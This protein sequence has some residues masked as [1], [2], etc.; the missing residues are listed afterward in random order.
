MPKIEKKN[1]IECEELK[2]GEYQVGRFKIYVER[3]E[4]SGVW[5][6]IRLKIRNRCIRTSAFCNSGFGY[7]DPERCRIPLIAIPAVLLVA[8]GIVDSSEVIE[9]IL[10]GEEVFKL[11]DIERAHVSLDVEERE[12][13]W[14]EAE[15]Y[16]IT[17]VPGRVIINLPLM[18]RLGVGFRSEDWEDGLWYFI[19]NP[20]EKKK[21]VL[22]VH[23]LYEIIL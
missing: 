20:D 18:R 9:K 12:T 11:D 23:I 16:G 3:K 6:P 8:E 5:I 13:I 19:D 7:I 10:G 4:L 17:K 21:S 1:Q 2:T 14:I 15:C 22:G